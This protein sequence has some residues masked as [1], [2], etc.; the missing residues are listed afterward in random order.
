LSS[1]PLGSV[2]VLAMGVSEFAGESE[3][4]CWEGASGEVAE[5][6]MEDVTRSSESRGGR[7]EDAGGEVEGVVG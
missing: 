2:L 4:I 7:E 1:P 6:G 3:L 5:R